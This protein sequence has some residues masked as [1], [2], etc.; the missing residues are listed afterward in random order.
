MK[1]YFALYQVN[2]NASAQELSDF[3]KKELRKWTMRANAPKKEIRDEAE[4]KVKEISEALDHF[5]D[6]ASKAAYLKALNLNNQ[7]QQQTPPPQ[8]RP[9]VNPQPNTNQMVDNLIRQ[10]QS[11]KGV[12]DAQAVNLL[13]Q[14]I[15]LNPRSRAAWLSLGTQ[16]LSMYKVGPQGVEVNLN[17]E[18]ENAYRKVFEFSPRDI[19][20]SL[21]LFNYYRNWNRRDQQK[22]MFD[23]FYPQI[24]DKSSKA[25]FLYRG[26]MSLDQGNYEDAVNCLE[27]V[28][29]Q[30]PEVREMT[31]ETL[32]DPPSVYTDVYYNVKRNLARA[33]RGRAEDFKVYGE[34][35]SPE[36]ADSYIYYMTKA[37]QV[38][39][40]D[41]DTANIESAQRLKTKKEFNKLKVFGLAFLAW[42]LSETLLIGIILGVFLYITDAKPGYIRN[43]KNLYKA[44]PDLKGIQSRADFDAK[45]LGNRS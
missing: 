42:A 12:N 15:N 4:A 39:S 17:R 11:F 45:R 27:E 13:T 24:K 8:P 21:N 22:Q 43:R 33:Y 20:A 26:L 3:F 35:I 29:K 30:G 44:H 36:D 28:Y 41:T 32:G 9:Q 31:F 2:P 14:A 34:L 18:G 19:L 10:A 7:P 6:E 40:R 5:K 16:Y 23:I 1:N 38:E 25:A 37:K